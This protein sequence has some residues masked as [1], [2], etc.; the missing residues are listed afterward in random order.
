VADGTADL[1]PRLGASNEWDNAA[2]DAVVRAAGGVVINVDTDQPVVYNKP[3]LHAS[4][5]VS[6]RNRSILTLN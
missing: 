5:F 4:P 6:A 3:D 2:G 1:Y